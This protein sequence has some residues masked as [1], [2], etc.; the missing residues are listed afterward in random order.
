MVLELSRRADDSARATRYVADGSWKFTDLLIEQ[1]PA[2]FFYASG[3]LVLCFDRCR[4]VRW[5]APQTLMQ[6]K[7][8][9]GTGTATYAWPM[10]TDGTS[11][12]A[13]VGSNG[14]YNVASF[15]GTTAMPLGKVPAQPYGGA[16]ALAVDATKVYVAAMSKLMV[17]DRVT[18][19]DAKELID[20]TPLHVIEILVDE[21]AVIWFDE[22]GVHAIAKADAKRVDLASFDNTTDAVEQV[23]Q[24]V[25]YVVWT[26]RDGLMKLRK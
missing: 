3:S 21:R 18:P 14:M 1:Y 7:M 16:R 13:E 12:Y 5:Y 24:N 22:G 19:G 10:G 6:T 25:D 17:V 4:F 8:Y 26:G 23:D 9:F 15:D 20:V 2:A 11:I